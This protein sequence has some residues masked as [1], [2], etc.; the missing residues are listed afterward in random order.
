MTTRVWTKSL[1]RGIPALLQVIAL[2]QADDYAREL[3]AASQSFAVR[4]L[5]RRP[6]LQYWKVRRSLVH[7]TFLSCAAGWWR[8]IVE[9]NGPRR[10]RVPKS[11]KFAL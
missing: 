4:H 7:P 6:R 8:W 3:A 2:R 5:G 10:V 1:M 11:G 9:R